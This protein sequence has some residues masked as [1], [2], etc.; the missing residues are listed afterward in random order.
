MNRLIQLVKTFSPKHRERE[1]I[2]R[3]LSRMYA[4][5]PVLSIPD[6]RGAF[7]LAPQSRLLYRLMVHGSYEQ[8]LVRL[9][10]SNIQTDRDVVDVGANVGFFSTL[11]AK[12]AADRRILAIEPTPGAGMRLDANLRRNGVEDQVIHFHGVVSDSR[13]QMQL[14]VIEGQEEFSSLGSIVHPSATGLATTTI[15][16]PGETIDHLVELHQLDVGY[17]KIDTEGAEF[18]VLRGASETLRKQR[19]IIVSELSDDL[20]CEKG[21]SGQE[22]IELLRDFDYQVSDP[23]TANRQPGTRRYGDILA[24]PSEYK[25]V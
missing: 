20:L 25:S 7:Q 18:L 9:I 13:G 8:G 21:S 11:F 5:D 19:P 4:E 14:S 3:M 1:R 22:V 16:V 17:I 24:V 10:E 15:D 12:L 2:L 6:F 23:F